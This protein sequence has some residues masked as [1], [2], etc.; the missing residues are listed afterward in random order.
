MEALLQLNDNVL[1]KS[2]QCETINLKYAGEESKTSQQLSSALLLAM[3]ELGACYIMLQ[4]GKGR[5]DLRHR[6]P[7]YWVEA[8]IKLLS[9]KAQVRQG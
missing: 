6:Q 7:M 8:G 4:E 2:I 9:S 1:S 3:Q 5:T